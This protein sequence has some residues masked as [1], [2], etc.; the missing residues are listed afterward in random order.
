MN[1]ILSINRPYLAFLVIIFLFAALTILSQSDA[2][3][4]HAANLSVGITADLLIVI[5]LFYYLLIRKTSIPKTTVIP[6]MV[7][8][9]ILGFYIIPPENQ[10][11]L[12]QFK[13]FALPAIEVA[14]LSFIIYK[15]RKAVVLFNRTKERS[16]DFFNVLIKICSEILPKALVMPFAT[17]VSVFYYGFMVWGKRKLTKDEFTHHKFSGATAVLSVFLLIILVETFV[18]HLL[19][20]RWNT[21]VAWIITGLSIY[22]ALQVW[23]II[24]SI[25]QRPIIIHG[26]GLTLRYGILNETFIPFENIDRIESFNKSINE[27]DQIVTLSPLGELEAYNILISLKSEGNM[28]GLYGIRKKYNRIA[29]HIDNK[30][31][32]L[33]SL[34]KLIG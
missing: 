8:G 15:V 34:Q 20:I 17:E 12:S 30:E 21:I 11:F 27:E 22:T 25:P 18:I 29:F 9:M 10:Y 23:G 31:E 4:I 1:K 33:S 3:N 5:P 13:S 19:L 14:I 26:N 7:V 2:F 28:K 6:I 24:K 16:K 32:F